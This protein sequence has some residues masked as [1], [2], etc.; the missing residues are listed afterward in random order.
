MH[1]NVESQAV[2]VEL[3]GGVDVV[4]DVANADIHDA[5]PD[6]LRSLPLGPAAESGSSRPP[7]ETKDAHVSWCRDGQ[8]H[9]CAISADGRWSA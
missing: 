3:D 4:H 1:V 8:H 6:L 7:R 9:Q 2:A 5:P